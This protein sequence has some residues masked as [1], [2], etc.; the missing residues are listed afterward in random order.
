MRNVVAIRANGS[1]DIGSGHIRRVS[2]LAESFR[3][4]GLTPILLC[5]PEAERVYPPM[6]DFFDAVHVVVS[7]EQA[8]EILGDC[9]GDRLWVVF[10]DSY[11][12][13]AKQ[14][15]IYR[16]CASHLVALDDMASRLMDVDLL[17]DVNLGRQVEDYNGLVPTGTPVH[18]GADYQILRSDFFQM[19][20]DTLRRR[21]ALFRV[22]KV[23]IAIGGTDPLQFSLAALRDVIRVSPKLHVDVVIGS[24]SPG[25][26]ELQAFVQSRT[27][28]IHLHIDAAEVAELMSQ[29]DVAIGA[30]GTMTWERNCLG[31]PTIILT[32]ADNQLEVG[33]FM[34]QAEAS[35]VLDARAGYP[36]DRVVQEFQELLDKPKRCREMGRKAAALGGCNGTKNI[37]RTV[38]SHFDDQNAWKV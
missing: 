15:R 21:D 19:R 37:V 35:V 32:I 11:D 1:Q 9:Y 23:F 3:E 7:E 14:H 5:N 12:L 4:H 30:G 27:E 6:K 36:S 31:L 22:E 13:D 8:V 2:L 26:A 10:F 20:A 28:R 33:R 16:H 38:L 24:A 25:L 29:A 34:Q 17:F 18:V